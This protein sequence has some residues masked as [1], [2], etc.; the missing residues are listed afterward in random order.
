M[1]ALGA[2]LIYRYNGANNNEF[3]QDVSGQRGWLLKDA[4][5]GSIVG[6][7]AHQ[8]PTV[9][10]LLFCVALAVLSF[11]KRLSTLPVL[12]LLINL[13]LMTQL[14]ISNWTLFFVWLLIGLAVYFG[15][16]YSNSKLNPRVRALQGTV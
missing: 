4:V 16:G 5:S 7:F 2:Y 11:R 12:G 6:G 13:Y 15:Y 3:W 8:I 10:F 14:G 1:L 9:V